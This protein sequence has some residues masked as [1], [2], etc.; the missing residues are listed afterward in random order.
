M[1]IISSRNHKGGKEAEEKEKHCDDWLQSG[2]M[3][4]RIGGSNKHSAAHGNWCTGQELLIV[5]ILINSVPVQVPMVYSF[6]IF[7]TV[8]CGVAPLLYVLAMSEF[9]DKVEDKLEDIWQFVTN[10]FTGIIRGFRVHPEVDEP[11]DDIL[12]V[13]RTES[14][15]N[16]NQTADVLLPNQ[17]DSAN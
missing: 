16:Q 17:P 3:A 2:R 1:N 5:T 10:K 9:R 7:S 6:M 12:V 4:G 8:S 11:I 15:T 13:Q 14:V